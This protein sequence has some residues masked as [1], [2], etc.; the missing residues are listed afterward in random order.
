MLLKEI[1]F[2]RY[3]FDANGYKFV[4]YMGYDSAG[5]VMFTPEIGWQELERVLQQPWE[6]LLED[7]DDCIYNADPD[8]F[9]VEDV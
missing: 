1:N 2:P 7:I 9:T 3:Q 5:R 4:V 8:R 6:T